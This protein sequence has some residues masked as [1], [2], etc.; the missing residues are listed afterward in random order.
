[1]IGLANSDTF[2]GLAVFA[3]AMVYA[4]DLGVWPGEVPRAIGVRIDHGTDDSVVP[5][6]FAEQ[7]ASSLQAA[8][9]PVVLSPLVG[10]SHAYDPSLH[11]DIW[12]SLS[13]WT[14]P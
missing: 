13:P 12:A 2:A 1:M 9:H 14:L 10:G 11:G 7:A 3:G 8:G 4:E 5:Y 6:S